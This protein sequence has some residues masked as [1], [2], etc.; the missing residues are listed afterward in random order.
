MQSRNEHPIHRAMA[1]LRLLQLISQNFL[2]FRKI[3]C[4]RPRKPVQ[5]HRG[6]DCFNFDQEDFDF[7]Q[8]DFNSEDFSFN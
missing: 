1:F 8:K 7:N 3:R 6:K 4:E 2:S 5:L